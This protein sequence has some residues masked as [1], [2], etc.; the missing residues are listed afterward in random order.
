MKRDTSVAKEHG[1]ARDCWENRSGVEPTLHSEARCFYYGRGD[2][3]SA[4]LVSI[5]ELV[6]LHQLC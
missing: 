4:G 1:R 2:I 6:A 5:P 3:C